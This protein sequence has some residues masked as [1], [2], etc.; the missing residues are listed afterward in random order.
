MILQ[1]HYCWAHMFMGLKGQLIHNFIDKINCRHL[2][3]RIEAMIFAMC[4][5]CTSLIK[6]IIKATEMNHCTV[7]SSTSSI[8]CL[9]LFSFF[10]VRLLSGLHD[11]SGFFIP[12]TTAKDLRLRRVSIP[13]FIHYIYFPILILEK[14]PVFTLLNV[15]C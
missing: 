6:E 14:G 2:C 5:C 4:F 13:D 10:S 3:L 12:A 11:H 15:Q 7:D 9:T 8:Q 1:Q